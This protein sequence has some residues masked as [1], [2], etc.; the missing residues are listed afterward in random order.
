LY[1]FIILSKE[2]NENQTFL[3][4]FL[5]YFS[6]GNQKQF[7]ENDLTLFYQNISVMKIKTFSLDD[8]KLKLEVNNYC[9]LPQK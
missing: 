3:K 6:F 1:K 7:E 8:I 2:S 5:A 9:N 4:S